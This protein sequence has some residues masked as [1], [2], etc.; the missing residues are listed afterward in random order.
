MKILFK[1]VGLKLALFFFT[2]G[3]GIYRLA[4]EVGNKFPIENLRNLTGGRNEEILQYRDFSDV[5]ENVTNIHNTTCGECN[6]LSND[7]G[8]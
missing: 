2:Q 7:S 5:K 8:V 1:S 4:V 3:R 6:S